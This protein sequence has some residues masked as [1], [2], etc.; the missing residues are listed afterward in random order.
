MISATHDE[1]CAPLGDALREF[2]LHTAAWVVE[3]GIRDARAL[4]AIRDDLNARDFSGETD[5]GRALLALVNCYQ[6]GES[7]RLV[8]AVAAW[9]RRGCARCASR[10]ASVDGD[11]TSCADCA[12]LDDAGEACP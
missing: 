10:I 3:A 1:S 4:G 11:A 12:A 6:R 7:T 2:G 5:A 9:D 8:R